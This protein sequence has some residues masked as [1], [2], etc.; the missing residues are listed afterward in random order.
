MIE[1]GIPLFFF[2]ATKHPRIFKFFLE[3]FIFGEEY[4]GIKKR[5]NLGFFLVFRDQKNA[6]VEQPVSNIQNNRT[7]GLY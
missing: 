5:Y 4:S 3:I 2:P 1:K 7:L 6:I